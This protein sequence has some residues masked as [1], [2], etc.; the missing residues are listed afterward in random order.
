MPAP[1]R[2]ASPFVGQTTLRSVATPVFQSPIETRTP[3]YVVPAGAALKVIGLDQ[4]WYRVE[5][6]APPW[7]G[8]YI[9]F[10]APRHI[11]DPS[12]ASLASVDSEPRD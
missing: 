7:G 4:G 11:T 3:L 10:I 9:G 2:D 5:F 8:P 6:T 12:P 1:P